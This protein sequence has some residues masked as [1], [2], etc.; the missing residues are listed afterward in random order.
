MD[1]TKDQLRA[2]LKAAIDNQGQ[3][4]DRI[5]ALEV[6]VEQI[7]RTHMGHF[8][9]DERRMDRLDERLKKLE[10]KLAP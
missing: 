8:H 5:Q 9:D 7:R 2:E 3:D 10:Q 4:R 6:L 1:G